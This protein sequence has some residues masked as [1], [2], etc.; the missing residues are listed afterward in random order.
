[1]A[2]SNTEFKQVLEQEAG[3]PSE[4]TEDGRRVTRELVILPD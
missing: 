3:Q 2:L 1:M 4:L